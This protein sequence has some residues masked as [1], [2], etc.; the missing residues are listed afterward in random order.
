MH[1]NHRGDWLHVVV[2]TD[3]GV[4]GVGEAS[5][6]SNDALCVAVL[7]QFAARLSGQDPRRI[8][9]IRQMLRR[10][11]A[12]RIWN[13]A[14]SGV[15]QA[16]WDILGQHLGVPVHQLF[17]GALRDRLRL[18]A[19][20]NRHVQDRSPEGFAR[21]AAQAVDQGFTAIKLAPFDEMR[22]PYRR[23]TGPQADWQ[24]GVAR[25]R[26]VRKAIGDAVEL[27]VDCHSR[28]EPSVAAIVG[29]ELAD[30]NLFWYEEPVSHEHPEA[31]AEVTR[32]AP[33]PT[34][35]AESIFG[36]EGFRPFL[37]QRTV[38]VIMPDVKHCGGIAEMNEIA[39][40]ARMHQV[41]VAPHNPAG[42]LSTAATAQVA[43][44]WPNFYILEY[45]WG[46]ADWRADLLDPPER[47]EA[48]HL[49]LSQEPGLGHRLNRR[50]VSTYRVAAPSRE[51][52]SM[53]RPG[54][55][56]SQSTSSH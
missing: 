45:A 15:E 28:M 10:K 2:E 14:L 37:A 44:T 38:D 17:G 36:V 20:I 13:T 8:A 5:H 55:T 56:E 50:T 43:A 18:Y 9:H 3:A 33:M 47:I 19:N 23:A 4:T 51:D 52:S 29:R 12:G 27:A 26:A 32:R 31:L 40:A 41:L 25:V 42:P 22:H 30:C 48:G 53:A 24:P 1:V 39:A 46:E 7:E 54:S 34:A 49:I 21:A 35:S 16:L 11:G 6:S